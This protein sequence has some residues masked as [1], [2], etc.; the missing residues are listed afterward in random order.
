MQKTMFYS[1]GVGNHGLLLASFLILVFATIF[2]SFTNYSN[3]IIYPIWMLWLAQTLP[4]MGILGKTEHSFVVVSFSLMALILL[5]RIIGYSSM[6]LLGLMNDFSWIMSGIVALF[7]MRYFSSN[8]LST[9][10]MFFS[11]GLL[12]LQLVYLGQGRA[13]LALGNEYEAVE[14][15]NAWYGS[16][17]MLLSGLSL[18]VFLNV[19]KMVPRLIAIS[20]LLLTL[21]LN[22]SI[23][24]RG[25]NVIMTLA[26]LGLILIF[27]I[28]RKSVIITLSII[29]AFFVIFALSSDN[30]VMIFDW[31]AQI[32]PSERISAR[33]NELSMVL[34]YESVEAGGGSFT[35]RG[36]LMGVSWN[37][38]I[39]SFGHFL[40]GAGEHAGDNSI[41]GHHS[42]ILDTLARYGIVGGI[43][44]IVYFINQYKIFTSG[45]D[46]KR[47][48]ALYMQC[49]I[50]FAFYVF[51][52]YYG[53]VA[54]SLVNLVLLV[55]FPL[56]FQLIHYYQNKSK[57]VTI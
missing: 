2:S 6:P 51:R 12:L 45:L 33:F 20:V 46:R 52:N 31:L 7:V 11:V 50:V 18:I 19:K 34:M 8:E 13:I 49:A 28:K 30:M 44:L 15:A 24:Q 16:L 35:A 48:W 4:N 3:Y 9:V 21:Y 22:V 41:I 5:Y 47:E 26:E 17:F 25:T 40:L 53:Q 39:S 27:L 38:F 43:L 56:T 14:V 37:T 29:V 32:S 42:F 10:Y 54:Y 36:E 1:R 57:S 55:F 23:L